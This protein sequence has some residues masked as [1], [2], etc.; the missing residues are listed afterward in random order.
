MYQSKKSDSVAGQSSSPAEPATVITNAQPFTENAA[1]DAS[2]CSIIN[3]WLTMRGDLESD[4]DI[5]VKGRVHG[6]IICKLLVIDTEAVVEGT[7]KAHEVIIRGTTRGLIQAHR[8]SVE[9]TARVDSEVF[10]DAIAI[11]EGARFKGALGTLEDYVTAT[12]TAVVPEPVERAVTAS[13]YHLL[14]QARSAQQTP[15]PVAR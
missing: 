9:K 3:A 6:N 12:A 13:L 11:E 5:L 4:G 10:Q 1:A 15:M 2:E 14:D 8:V 7:I